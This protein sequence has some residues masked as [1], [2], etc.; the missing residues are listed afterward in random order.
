MAVLQM[1]K[2]HICALK[3]NRKQ[4]LE[5][6]QRKGIVQIEAAGDSD[7]FQHMDTSAGCSKYEKYAQMAEQ[8]LKAL[9]KFAP[10]KKGLLSSFEGRR[11]IGLDHY[12]DMEKN[13]KQAVQTA[14]KILSL[15]RQIAEQKANLLRT[16][17]LYDALL[18]WLN[19]DVPMNYTGTKST[20]AFIGSIPESHSLEEV[21][22]LLAQAKPTLETSS[23]EIISASDDQTCIFA[24]CPKAQADEMDDAL[25]QIGFA[26]PSVQSTMMPADYWRQL[27]EQMA[28]G[29]EKITEIEAQLADM[30]KHRRTLELMHD[31]YTMRAEK[32]A[33]LGGLLQSDHAFF[34]NG[35]TPAQSAEKLHNE[36]LGS[37]DCVVE[38]EDIPEDEEAPV[39]LKNNRFNAPTEGVLAS[40]GLPRKGEIDPTSVMAFCYYF[41]FGLMLSDAAYGLIMAIG[42]FLMLRKFKG[43]EGGMKQMLTMFMYCGISTTFWGVMFGSYF[44]DA[45][46]VIA[47]TFF[48]KTITIPAVWMVPLDNPMRMLIFCFLFG[49][50]HLF[51]GLGMK[52]Y[53]LLRDRQYMDFFSDVL[54]WVVMLLGLLFML[55]PSEL[56][57]SISQM[58]FHFPTLVN[59]IAKWAAIVGAVGIVLFAK[60]STRNFGLR[61]ALGAY[62]L[63][64]ATSWLSDV[65]SYSRL[66]ALGLATG[67]IASVIN[68]M[69]AMVGSG[70]FGAIVF[71]LVFILGHTLNLAI[72]VLGAY[73][74]TNRLQFVEF[75]GKFY[76]GGG[77]AFKPFN[78]STKYIKI[79]EEK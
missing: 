39:L 56:F 10:E 68:Q 25:R 79:S 77:S 11:K 16:Q 6:L 5:L 42:C 47:E 52:G 71:I 32:Y 75:F 8:A 55:L 35:Y 28:A 31:Y 20:R 57:R 1:Q 45:I 26:R 73:V 37:Y 63:Y 49:I 48:G 33:V 62:E 15:N 41:L 59:V 76:E 29:S 2:I 53:M 78:A 58:E 4:I 51:L 69:G 24:V 43:M 36:L 70:I 21:L 65:L 18:P 64:G 72:N 14:D 30:G 67:V 61:L 13:R 19:L 44:G 12:C 3:S 27:E 40:F 17:V 23:V 74:H 22:T 46:T 60:R 50:L 34:L 54:L 7:F 66:L 38:L 9:D